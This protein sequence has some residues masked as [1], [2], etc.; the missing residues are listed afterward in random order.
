MQRIRIIRIIGVIAVLAMVAAACSSGDDESGG[1]T[2]GT[3]GGGATAATGSTGALSEFGESTDA[4]PAL[5]EKALG[6]VTPSDEASWNI[7]L[8]SVA[9]VAV[10]VA[11]GYALRAAQRAQRGLM[12]VK[13]QQSE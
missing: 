2:T 6:D 10:A 8:A 13:V 1:T 12:P 3:T 7:I 4:D 9:P 5:I 11:V